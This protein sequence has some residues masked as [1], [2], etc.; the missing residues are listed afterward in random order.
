M[1]SN[2]SDAAATGEAAEPATDRPA[3]GEGAEPTAQAAT[4][5]AAVNEVAGAAEGA[6]ASAAAA[7]SPLGP[8]TAQGESTLRSVSLKVEMLAALVSKME[9]LISSAEAAARTLQ[10]K[11]PKY[12]S[13]ECIWLSVQMSHFMK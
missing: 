10:V 3:G 4:D 6:E 2:K 9:H 12:Y 7:D 8:V 1:S 13:P 5:G 11:D